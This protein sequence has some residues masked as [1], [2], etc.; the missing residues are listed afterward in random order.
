MTEKTSNPRVNAPDTGQW[1]QVYSTYWW[2]GEYNPDQKK[3]FF[4][5]YSKKYGHNEARDKDYLLISRVMM[6]L[7][8]GYFDK[9][10]QIEIHQRV[11]PCCMADDPVILTL[12][13]NTFAMAPE[14]ITKREIYLQLKSIYEV[15]SNKLTGKYPLQRPKQVNESMDGQVKA[16]TTKRYSTLDDVMTE[17][18]RL[19]A[20]GAAEG[21]VSDAYRK[22]IDRNPKLK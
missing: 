2:R 1:D 21:Q 9:C 17:M 4:K 8:N 20:A 15:R 3:T 12:F 13:P 7:K 6:L 16:A 22:I 19:S 14:I 10:T 5:G 18:H 11:G